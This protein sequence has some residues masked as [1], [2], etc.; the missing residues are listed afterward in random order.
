MKSSFLIFR[1]H[2]LLTGEI[3]VY[4]CFQ[5]ND[6]GVS[7][8]I[9][10]Y[11]SACLL[12][13]LA[14][15][16]VESIHCTSCKSKE[17]AVAY[18]KDCSNFLCSN[19]NIAHKFMRCFENHTVL[20]LSNLDGQNLSIHKPIYCVHHKSEHLKFF[21][22]TCQ[23]PICN[24]CLEKEH[25]SSDHHFEDAKTAEFR[26]RKELE[27]LIKESRSKGKFC[28]R[29]T[30]TL[31]SALEDLQQQHDTAKD[32]ITESFHSY[33]AILEK[34]KVNA[35]NKLDQL[36][37]ERELKI[38]DIFHNLDE[39]VE[40]IESACNFTSRLLQHG[41]CYELITLKQMI[42]TQLLKLINN[43]PKP[44]VSFSIEFETDIDKFE[45][46]IKNSFGKFQTE[47]TR[48]ESPV[49]TLTNLN[50]SLNHTNSSGI[51]MSNRCS[52]S[53]TTSSPISLPTSMQSSFD[54][55][56]STIST[57]LTS[58]FNIAS[59]GLPVDTTSAN[60]PVATGLQLSSI[61]EYNLQQLASLAEKT[62][63]V[64]ASNASSPSPSFSLADLFTGDISSTN[65]VLNNLQALAKLGLNGTGNILY[66][67][68][69][70]I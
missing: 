35:L 18:C 24:E 2:L 34:C 52:T 67:T 59:N 54:S 25:T 36:H 6:K 60:M 29:T 4:H 22:F 10:D 65:N 11:I 21:C 38:M 64:S 53:L 50:P 63:A 58:N 41:N 19:C 44:E 51:G 1:Y 3:K 49:P 5:I 69:Y 8:L 23:V 66:N 57:S 14:A 70:L 33:K 30:A 15:D 37:S 48:S 32:L 40:K 43:T 42:S 26:I 68:F 13:P 20:N 47:D 12:D 31:E 7:S 46:S 62:D 39:T 9:P 55:E 45:N 28:E 16:N 27:S 17:E 56:L 61:A